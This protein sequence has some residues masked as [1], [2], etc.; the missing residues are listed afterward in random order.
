VKK[1]DEAK[2]ARIVRRLKK[3]YPDSETE[4][5]HRSALQLLVATILSAQCTDERVN[6]VTPALFARYKT[7][8]DFAEADPAEVEDLI[9]STGFFRNKTKSVIGLGKALVA[10]HGG[11]VPDAMDEL[12]KLPGVGRKTAN[13][14]LGS[15]FKRPAIPVDTHVLRVSG[16]LGLTRSSDPVE[17]ERDLA[18]I[19]PERDWTFTSSA[20]IWHGRR[21]CFARNPACERCALLPDCPFGN[22]RPSSPFAILPASK[23]RGGGPTKIAP[24]G[25]VPKHRR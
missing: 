10:G 1:P 18:R 7:A 13:V 12:V 2:V 25:A 20:L 22:G 9:R 19:L 8:K 15:W 4:L 24:G 16:R 17:V 6:Q 23:R 14:L 5:A 21:V 11:K 3:L